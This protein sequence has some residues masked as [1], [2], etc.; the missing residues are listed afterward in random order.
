MDHSN[1]IVI[2]S[3]S[4]LLRISGRK[5]RLE[6]KNRLK[7]FLFDES[8]R[9]NLTDCLKDCFSVTLHFDLAPELC[10]RPIREDQEG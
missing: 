2:P 10:D 7:V 5:I 4:P 1:L 6:S 9:Q 3:K 8:G